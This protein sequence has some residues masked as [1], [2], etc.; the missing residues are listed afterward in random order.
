[1][2]QSQELFAMGNLE[3]AMANIKETGRI[4]KKFPSR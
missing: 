4:E 3:A 2:I 1:M